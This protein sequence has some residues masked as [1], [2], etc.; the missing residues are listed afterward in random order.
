MDENND[1][2][3]N[4]DV[5]KDDITEDDKPD[6]DKAEEETLEQAKERARIAEEKA[7]KA[8]KDLIA[9]KNS[10]KEEKKKADAPDIEA[11]VDSVLQKRNEKSVLRKV[12]DEKS[13]LFIPELVDDAQYRKIIGY[14]PRNVDRSS[15]EGIHKALK[16]AVRSWKLDS[17]DADEKKT[18]RSLESDITDTDSKPGGKSGSDAK[19]KFTHAR[20]TTNM[21][22]WYKKK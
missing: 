12:V 21:S 16:L 20:P 9:V 19:K 8:M 15:E 7:D 4:E 10:R 3:L 14:L 5:D 6:A 11:E 17:G 1:R 13:D 18:G 22:D 2:T